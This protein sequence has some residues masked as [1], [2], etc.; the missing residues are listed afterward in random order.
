MIGNPIGGRSLQTTRTW[1]DT[2]LLTLLA[3]AV[4]GVTAYASLGF[5]MAIS[6]LHQLFVGGSGETLYSHLAEISPIFLFMVP[7]VGAVVV[8]LIVTYGVPGRRNYGPA[9]VIQAARHG[10]GRMSLS[11]KD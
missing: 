5:L 3:V 10:D 11:E 7:V 9:D 8:S 6:W 1:F 4:G 2:F